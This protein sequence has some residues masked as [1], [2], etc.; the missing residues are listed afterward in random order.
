L[1]I[2]QTI[3]KLSQT[4]TWEINWAHFLFFGKQIEILN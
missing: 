2:N 1:K 3:V 4:T